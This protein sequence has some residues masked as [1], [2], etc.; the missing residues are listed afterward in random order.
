ML[1]IHHHN[2]PISP[3]Y[4]MDLLILSRK[5]LLARQVCEDF[6]DRAGVM[7]YNQGTV[8]DLSERIIQPPRTHTLTA[9]NGSLKWHPLASGG[10]SS[11]W[12]PAGRTAA[13]Q[14]SK[15]GRAGGMSFILPGTGWRRTTCF[16]CSGWRCSVCG[17]SPPCR[18]CTGGFGAQQSVR[19]HWRAISPIHSR[20]G[21]KK[22]SGGGCPRVLVPKK[23]FLPHALSWMVDTA[24]DVIRRPGLLLACYWLDPRTRVAQAAAAPID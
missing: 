16:C 9:P 5:L 10:A 22:H 8:I 1:L 23:P 18:C 13:D 4:S 7:R 15:A 12:C 14:R 2:I 24:G 6:H 19:R 17:H 21:W 11:L 20:R 3:Y